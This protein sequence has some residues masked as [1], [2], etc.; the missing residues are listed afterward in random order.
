MAENG[1]PR[2]PLRRAPFSVPD[3]R[4]V[5]PTTIFDPSAGPEP[6]HPRTFMKLDFA[7]LP[8]LLQSP[9][10]PPIGEIHRGDQMSVIDHRCLSRELGAAH[11]TVQNDAHP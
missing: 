3:G 11:P 10:S 2:K 8:R 4:I 7:P 5:G 6:R 1:A 9:Q